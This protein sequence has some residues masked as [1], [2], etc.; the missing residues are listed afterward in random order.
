MRNLFRRPNISNAPSHL[1]PCCKQKIF[2]QFFFFVKE[3]IQFQRARSHTRK[4]DGNKLLENLFLWLLPCGDKP[5]QKNGNT[6]NQVSSFIHIVASQAPLVADILKGYHMW[7]CES[8]SLNHVFPIFS[9]FCSSSYSD[10]LPYNLPSLAHALIL[11]GQVSSAI[12]I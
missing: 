12:N 9:L 3:S 2:L 8:G 6:Q 5:D 7:V 11:E 1:R 4:M 10:V